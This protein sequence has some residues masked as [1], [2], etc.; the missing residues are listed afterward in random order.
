[1][2][3]FG[4]D[5]DWDYNRYMLWERAVVNALS[6]RRGQAALADL[7]TALL[8]LPEPRLIEGALARDGEV[9]AVG[10]LVLTNRCAAGEDRA[11]VL[12][13]LERATDPDDNY[14]ADDV[15]ASYGAKHGRMAYAMAWRIAELND[16]DC[17]NLTPE[18]RYEYVL[19]WVR[20]A[21]G[22]AS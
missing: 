4:D 6:G 10:A 8:A 13:E 5:C 19:S 2:S 20:K 17:R 9:C 7:E 12:A 18:G 22:A 11:A 16:E 1:M 3:R 21:R 15:T 14:L